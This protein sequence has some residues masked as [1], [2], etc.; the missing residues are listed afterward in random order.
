MRNFRKAALAGATA[1]AVAFGST[2]VATAETVNPDNQ[3]GEAT[4]GDSSLSSRIG[5][6][7][8][9]DQTAYGPALFGSSHG[10]AEGE[11]EAYE[12]Q[13]AWA[14]L[15]HALTI[16]TAVSALVGMIVGPAYNFVVHG[17]FNV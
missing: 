6:G 2:A 10:E 8:E 1:V 9:G 17:P 5:A 4:A 3:L 7:L 14:K 11:T 12:Q 13:P 15:F 16:F